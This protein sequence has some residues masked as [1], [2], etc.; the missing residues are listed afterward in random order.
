VRIALYDEGADEALNIAEVAGYLAQLVGVETELRG[1]PFA[2]DLPA[3]RVSDYARRIAQTKIR[4]ITKKSPPGQEPLPAEIEYEKRRILGRT[5]AFGVPYDGLKLQRLFCEL[6]P[7]EELGP[8]FVHIIFT[9][10]LFATWD[11]GDKRYHLRTS[12][13]AVPCLISTSG[14]VEAPAKPREY[15]LAKQQYERLGK[16]P[17][18]LK[19]RF[20]GSFL[21]YGDRRLTE[22]AK[23]YA[24]QA[25][26]Y[27]LTGEPFCQD[28][29]CRLYNAHWQEEMLFAQLGSEYEFCPRH[30]EVLRNWRENDAE[31][32]D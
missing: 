22:V 26:F 18:E 32:G 31:R 5:K 20:R 17:L 7:G 6:I 3:E 9:N 1:S 15:Y 4:E 19:E 2:P 28:K 23:G 8:E 11:E 21:D 14:L 24:M 16:D 30:A 29:G 27:A 25:V 12:L 13:Y 10:R